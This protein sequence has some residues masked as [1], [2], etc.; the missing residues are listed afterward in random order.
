M[1][2]QTPKPLHQRWI[3]CNVLNFHQ[4]YFTINREKYGPSR[5]ARDQA[6]GWGIRVYLIF[7]LLIPMKKFSVSKPGMKCQVV[8]FWQCSRKIPWT[9][10]YVNFWFL[11]SCDFPPCKQ[12]TCK[13]LV[14]WVYLKYPWKVHA[15]RRFWDCHKDTNNAKVTHLRIHKLT[16]WR[17]C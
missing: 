12:K 4:T 6:L 2:V 7:R 10:C 8:H 16:N 5:E 14:N 15:L 9:I 17:P 13:I 1:R 3:M 11:Q